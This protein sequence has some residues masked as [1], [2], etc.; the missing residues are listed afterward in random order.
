MTVFTMSL[1]TRNLTPC[2]CLSSFPLK[3]KKT[4]CPSSVVVL[5]RFF[6]LISQSPRIFHLYLSVSCV[7]SWSFPATLSVLVFQV[8]MVML[9]L[10]R[11]FDDAPVVCLTPPSW[12]TEGGAVLVNLSSYR[13]D[14]VWSLVSLMVTEEQSTTWRSLAHPSPGRIRGR[15]DRRGTH[16]PIYPWSSNYV[17][18]DFC[19]VMRASY[20]F[21]Y[22]SKGS[23]HCHMMLSLGSG[24][25]K[26]TWTYPA[27]TVF[28]CDL[29]GYL[30]LHQICRSQPRV[31]IV[32]TD[33]VISENSVGK[34][35]EFELVWYECSRC[36]NKFNPIVEKSANRTYLARSSRSSDKFNSTVEWG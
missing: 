26:S 28:L 12:C 3:K 33:Y 23:A 27:W 15:R 35:S 1:L 36:S 31:A 22:R 8:P 20:S 25:V 9:S 29:S 34:R 4:L 2:S 19:S 30:D 17:Y 11:I 7:S 13:S 5:P 10:P 6:H 16:P 21:P 24:Q 32:A 18:E 14:M